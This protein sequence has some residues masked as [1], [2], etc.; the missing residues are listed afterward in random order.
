MRDGDA[1]RRIGKSAELFDDHSP[2]QLGA[3]GPLPGRGVHAGR[4]AAVRLRRAAPGTSGTRCSTAA[5]SGWL[6][7]DNG[8][9]VFAFDAPLPGAAP[10]ADE[11]RVGA[12]RAGRRPGVAASPRSRARQ[13]DRRPGRAAARRRSS[14]GAFASPTCATRAARSARSTTASRR[15]GA[16]RS[17]ARCALAELALTGPA[18]RR[19][20]KTLSGQGVRSA[21]TAARRS[22]S[23]WRPRS[24]S[25][26]TSAT[27][28]STCRKG[29]GGDLAHYAQ[30]NGTARAADP[31][32]QHRHAARSARPRRCRGRWSATSERCDVPAGRRRTSRPSGASTC[33]TTAARLRLPGRQRGRLELGRAAHRRARRCAATRR[34]LPGR[35]L[36]QAVRLHRQG[37]LGARRVLL[38][39]AARPAHLQQR[40]RGHRQRGQA[41]DR[42][43]TGRRRA[44]GGLVGGETLDRRRRGQG[45]PPRAGQERRARSATPAPTSLQRRRRWLRARSVLLGR[46]SSI[47]LLMLFALRQRRR[48]AS[49]G[50]QRRRLFGAAAAARSAAIP[51]AAATSE[52]SAQLFTGGS[53]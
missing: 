28:W 47:V 34:D 17:A 22:R 24:R 41:P 50:R 2:L 9:Y 27:R 35:D 33:C 42:E 37:H 38:A 7:E 48:P 46:S 29:V 8:A 1:L 25:P 52:R 36:P 3:R 4:P 10:P 40:L 31:A 20:E 21:R 5:R 15:A 30:A 12:R 26:A 18:P 23:S 45:L 11:L 39:R 13:A 49:R 19:R 51:A 32:R 53:P 14:S 44:R 6:S 43:Q 16:G